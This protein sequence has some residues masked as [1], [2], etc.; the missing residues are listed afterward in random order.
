MPAPLSDIC[1]LHA[2]L[3]SC[4]RRDGCSTVSKFHKCWGL[5]TLTFNASTRYQSALFWD[6]LG[7][8]LY[9]RTSL[10][11]GPLWATS[12]TCS[13]EKTKCVLTLP[14][15][16]NGDGKA[17]PTHLHPVRVHSALSKR[18][19]ILTEL[20][21]TLHFQFI[22]PRSS[23]SSLPLLKYGSLVYSVSTHA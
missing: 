6:G 14:S 11:A 10:T 8:F 22:R 12:A 23:E 20:K 9:V 16:P 15:S 17:P 1:R 19:N 7:R 21:A 2:P 4:C 13:A 5:I 3:L 18:F